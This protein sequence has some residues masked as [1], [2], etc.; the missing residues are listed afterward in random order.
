MAKMFYTLTEVCE[1]LSKS[2]TEVEAMVTSGQIQEF[3]DGEALV[4][5]VE[6]IELLTSNDDSG[7]LD[8]NLDLN[9]S[10]LELDDSFGLGESATG[11][12]GLAGSQSADIPTP[13]AKPD[14]SGGIEESGSAIG[15]GSSSMMSGGGLASKDLDLSAELDS[16]A[17]SADASASAFDGA[18]LDGGGDTQ[19]GEGLDDD[20]TLESVGSGS[21][22]LDLTRESDDTSL[23]AE[24]LEEVY[25]SEDDIDFPAA[26]GLFEASTEDDEAT[27]A[28]V[29]AIGSQAAPVA[30]TPVMAAAQSWDPTWSGLS[31][32]LMIGGLVALVA[33][34]AIT[35]VETMGGASGIALLIAEQMWMWVGGLLACTIVLGLIGW[36]VGGKS[37]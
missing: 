8:L 33:V 36:V 29:A 34:F 27:P 1:K 2:E 5:K 31:A 25:S 13:A 26:S 7:E 35:A 24:L 28:Q 30:A 10:S 4:F 18:A 9:S 32:G 17:D 22:L 37:G 6:Q 12:I 23:G 16:P 21:G 11:S 20:L 14:L 3:R 19:L 15:L